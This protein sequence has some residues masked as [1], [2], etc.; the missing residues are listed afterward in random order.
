[1]PT[2]RDS[3]SSTVDRRTVVLRRRQ[4]RDYRAVYGRNLAGPSAR[5]RHGSWLRNQKSWQGDGPFGPR[6]HR[7]HIKLCPPSG[8]ARRDRPRAA[9]PRVLVWLG[10]SRL[11]AAGY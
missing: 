5:Q 3:R 8:D 2:S 10:G 7:R 6:A 4:L 1:M 11:L 9:L